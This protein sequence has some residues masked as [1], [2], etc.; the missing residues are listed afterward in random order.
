MKRTVP[1]TE[2]ALELHKT[3]MDLAQSPLGAVVEDPSAERRKPDT[4]NRAEIDLLCG[5]LAIVA[6]D[7]L[8]E[9]LHGLIDEVEN[10]A[11]LN[12]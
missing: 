12:L 1:N 5:K 8:C 3:G 6:C 10:E 11:I 9:A 2:S 4:H 7:P